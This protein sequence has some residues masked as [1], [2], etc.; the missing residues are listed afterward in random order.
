MWENITS[1]YLIDLYQNNT[2]LT[3]KFKLVIYISMG[4]LNNNYY[5]NKKRTLA[6]IFYYEFFAGHYDKLSPQQLSELQEVLDKMKH[7]TLVIID[8]YD[9]SIET[10]KNDGNIAPAFQQLCSFPYII[11]TST[12]MDNVY[13]YIKPNIL[14]KIELKNK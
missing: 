8:N 4:N 14:I 11:I 7:N 13:K 3:N 5:K 1:K 6:Q 9:E 12:S 2:H 10:V